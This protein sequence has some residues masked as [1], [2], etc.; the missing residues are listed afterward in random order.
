M[1]VV[2]VR[3]NDP[4]CGDDCLEWIA[5]DGDIVDTTPSAFSRVFAKL[6]RKKLPIIIN[7]RGGSVEAGLA[8]GRMIRARGFDVGVATTIFD[9]C[10]PQQLCK[11][12]APVDG[13]RAAIR[14][15]LGLC[16]SACAFILGG[17]HRRVSSGSGY[18]GVHQVKAFRTLVQIHRTYKVRTR[19]VR[20]RK[21]V[22]RR[23]VGERR[24]KARTVPARV[25]D[26]T[27]RPIRTFLTEMG[28]DRRL[29]DMMKSTPNESMRWL[30]LAERRS[31]RLI[32]E[33][34]GV[35]LLFG[36]Q[37]RG[38]GQ[39]PVYRAPESAETTVELSPERRLK[40][41]LRRAADRTDVVAALTT[42]AG[43]PVPRPSGNMLLE[44]PAGASVALDAHPEF[45]NAWRATLAADALCS[46]KDPHAVALVFNLSERAVIDLSRQSGLGL[47]ARKL[48]ARLAGGPP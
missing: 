15:Q 37:G 12:D 2:I 3:S 48:C 32:T 1:R 40:V 38:S 21:Q 47:F 10:G 9:P 31:T 44:P 24:T 18:V 39:L 30:T 27:Y 8:I 45:G 36:A 23:L 22:S 17:G 7:S 4:A 6:G 14:E 20:G 26:A 19:T 33:D 11:G 41:T 34:L 46:G 29:I 25:T 13:A 35:A 16:A 28:L 42:T 5:A 43:D